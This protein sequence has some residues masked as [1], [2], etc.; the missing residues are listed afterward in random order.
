[1]I[2]YRVFFVLLGML[3]H[4]EL[5]DRLRE[6][7]AAALGA[8]AGHIGRGDAKVRAEFRRLERRAIPRVYPRIVGDPDGEGPA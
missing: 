3:E 6:S 2:P 5:G 8:A 4:L 7:E 1:M